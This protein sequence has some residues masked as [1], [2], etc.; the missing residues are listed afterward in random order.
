MMVVQLANNF[1]NPIVAIFSYVNDMKTAAPIW[2]RFKKISRFEAPETTPHDAD[3]FKQLIVKDAG[4]KLG[5]RQIFKHVDLTIYPGEK[6]L[7]VAPSAW[8]KSTLLIVLTGNKTF[9]EG[10]Y[11]IDGQDLIGN[12]NQDQVYVSFIQQKPLILTDTPKF[13]TL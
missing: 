1:I 13:T 5:G 7:L 2:K 8:G 6:L 12:W 9:T 4:V 11:Q 3:H 10:S